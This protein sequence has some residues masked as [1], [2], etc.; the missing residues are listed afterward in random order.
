MSQPWQPEPQQPQPGGGNPYAQPPGS[1]PAPPPMPPGPPQQGF[2]GQPAGAPPFPGQPGPGQPGMGGPGQPG[3]APG[4]PGMAPG[5]PGMAPGQPYPYPGQPGQRSAPSAGAA[6]GAFF[7]ALLASVVVSVIYSLVMFFMREDTT[8]GTATTL[9]LVHAAVNAAIAGALAGL[10]GR[11]SNGAH[12][13]AGIVGVLGA[14]FGFTNGVF[15]VLMDAPGS[16]PFFLLKEEPFLPA[17]IWWDSFDQNPLV[18]LLGLLIA[19]AAGWGIARLTGS[20]R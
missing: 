3:M 5:Q 18:P 17:Q 6:V 10:V 4:Q 14:F 12:I 7:L 15:F 19:A 8:L 1:A 2:G 9:Y 16:D 13:G 11:R 20:R